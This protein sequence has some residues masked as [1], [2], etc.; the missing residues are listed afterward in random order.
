MPSSILEA[1]IFSQY[2]IHANPTP[3][4]VRIYQRAIDQNEPSKALLAAHKHPFLLPY[5]DAHDAFFRPTSQLRGRLYLMFSILEASTEFTDKFLASR[6]SKL[7]IFVAI[8][9]GL[10]A[11]CRLSIGTII[12]VTGGY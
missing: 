1:T 2:L 12:A 6:R 5:L 9:I 11:L 7:Y 8:L 3:R 10:R 4:Q